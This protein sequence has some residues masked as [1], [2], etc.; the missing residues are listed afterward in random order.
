MGS[1]VKQRGSEQKRA[2]PVVALTG[3]LL[4]WRRLGLK[5]A[6]QELGGRLGP[7][8][9]MEQCRLVGSV[10]GHRAQGT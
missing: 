10:C 7:G 1:I 8:G 3:S 4:G 2:P 9:G 6:P 5:M